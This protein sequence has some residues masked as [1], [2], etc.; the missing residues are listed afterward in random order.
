MSLL[1]SV[2]KVQPPY[3]V[4]LFGIIPPTAGAFWPPSTGI[5][6]TVMV[7]NHR[8]ASPV[9]AWGGLSGRH[10]DFD[11]Q[12]RRLEQLTELPGPG[13]HKHHFTGKMAHRHDGKVFPES[14]RD[15]VMTHFPG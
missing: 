2:S 9:A 13:F 14:R 15:L 12:T 1:N 3:F 8:V 5:V 7:I 4:M 11:L 6:V 10:H